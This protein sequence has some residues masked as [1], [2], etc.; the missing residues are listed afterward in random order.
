MTAHLHRIEALMPVLLL[1]MISSAA[2]ATVPAIPS[3][4]PEARAFGRGVQIGIC[5]GLA[6]TRSG[7]ATATAG[8]APDLAITP[9]REAELA[10]LLDRCADALLEREARP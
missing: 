1:A 6:A 7:A 8:P 3:D 4:D 9:G 2:A 10:Q 5:W